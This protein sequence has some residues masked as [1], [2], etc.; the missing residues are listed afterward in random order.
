[1]L[2]NPDFRRLL[3]NFLIEMVIYGVLLVGYFLLV[4]RYLA[5][6][7]TQLFESNL[8]AYGFVALG[9]MALQAVAL[10]GVTTLLVRLG[11]FGHFGE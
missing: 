8:V 10:D 4:L 2:K 11:G 6:P 7:L 1:M 9:L 3:R 5:E